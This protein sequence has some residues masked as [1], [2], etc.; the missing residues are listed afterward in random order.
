MSAGRDA[1]W[2]YTSPSCTLAIAGQP[3]RRWWG[4]ARSAWRALWFELRWL[5]PGQD[6]ATVVRGDRAQLELLY[7][8]LMAAEGKRELPAQAQIGQQPQLRARDRETYELALGSGVSEGPSA[9][10]PLSAA[11]LTDLA[12]VLQAGN[13]AIV[14][15]GRQQRPRALAAGSLVLLGIGAAT[16]ASY[17]A[18]SANAP[19]GTRDGSRSPPQPERERDGIA[20]LPTPADSGPEPPAAPE[21]PSASP[22]QAATLQPPPG[23]PQSWGE[24]IEQILPF[25]LVPSQP[26]MPPPPQ[27]S[28]PPLEPP[29]VPIPALP[30][31]ANWAAQAADS[32][33]EP[34]RPN[35]SS[36]ASPPAEAE[37]SPP[38]QSPSP[39]S[40]TAIAPPS[41]ADRAS[42]PVPAA[43]PGPDAA[44]GD[45][46]D[47][48]GGKTE[49]ATPRPNPPRDPATVPTLEDRTLQNRQELTA[50]A[51]SLP[52]Q[53]APDEDASKPATEPEPSPAPLAAAKQ[54]DPQP[55][56]ERQLEQV[57][58]Y[59]QQRWEPPEQLAQALEYRLVLAPDGSLARAIPLGRAARRHLAQAN[60][61]LPQGPFVSALA[62]EG[63]PQLRLVLEPSGSVQTFLQSRPAAD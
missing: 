40:T 14:G 28:A 29:Q 39:R 4:R 34:P 6:S 36:L 47:D 61:L 46:S 15:Q 17:L 11:Q 8:A 49:A 38:S 58:Q 55:P 44:S 23:P 33:P 1:C 27:R 51:P 30:E 63:K 22:N 56:A 2:H 24:R 3:S 37:P 31:R 16:A 26:S 57:Q 48:A 35:Q 13:A 41:S 12:Q 62:G 60:G 10:I 7:Q 52:P 54:R 32:P 18:P 21:A 20:S 45:H 19:D 25:P 59:F 43:E 9:P 5:Q 42:E 50:R 53:P